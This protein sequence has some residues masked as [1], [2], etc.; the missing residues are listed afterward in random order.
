LIWIKV[1]KAIWHFILKLFA[2]QATIRS[3]P[4][5]R[6]P[7]NE[8]WFDMDSKVLNCSGQNKIFPLSFFSCLKYSLV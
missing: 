2:V 5:L 7:T 3:D 4:G 1:E 8:S 6:K